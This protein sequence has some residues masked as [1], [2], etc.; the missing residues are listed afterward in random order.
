MQSWFARALCASALCAAPC[1]S[2][3]GAGDPPVRRAL[4]VGVQ[5]YPKAAGWPVLQ[6]PRDDVAAIARVLVERGGFASADVRTLLDAQATHAAIR[7]A[8]RSLAAQSAKGDLLLFY[9]AGHGSR[10]P[11]EEGGDELDGWDETLIP[12]DALDD[13]G[14][15]ND[16]RDDQL[17][18]WVREANARVEDV[19]LVF[20]CCSSGTNSRGGTGDAVRFV[21]PLARGIAGRRG[22]RLVRE[23]GSGWLAPSLS[24]VSLGACRADESAFE[25]V[26]PPDEAGRPPLVR[27]LF[28]WC[29][30]QELACA[31]PQT[32]YAELGERVRDAV[33]RVHPE[34]SPVV[35]GPL[36][37]SRVLGGRLGAA[38]P[39]FALARRGADWELEAGRLQ[40][41]CEGALLDVRAGDGAVLGRVRVDRPGT[42]RSSAVWCVAPPPDAGE[43]LRAQLV[44]RGRGLAPVPVVLDAELLALDAA[45]VLRERIGASTSLAIAPAS[46]LGLVLRGTGEAAVVLAGDGAEVGLSARLDRPDEVRALVQ[47][48]ERW[49]LA[50][51]LYASLSR[52]RAVGPA[53]EVELRRADA[54]GRALDRLPLDAD[55][56]RAVRDGDTIVL[57]LAC[58]TQVHATLLSFAPDGAI[59]V[60]WSSLDEG[61]AVP[62]AK[63]LDLAFRMEIDAG[64]E[65]FYRSAPLRFLWIVSAQ[66]HGRLTALAQPAA[67]AAARGGAAE[68]RAEDGLGAPDGWS[69]GG[70]EL[71]VRRREP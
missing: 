37:E 11:D 17:R 25:H 68:A 41:L 58:P 46:E 9:F 56:A 22:G 63:Q 57:R 70:V 27:G 66:P 52:A 6:G 2:A 4:L 19:V 3:F 26:L 48:L 50:R 53:L 12:V 54:E 8:F 42:S 59:T 1:A 15:P 38:P 14:K 55:G 60:L 39:S 13:S 32:S 21:D 47:G 71:C 64:S 43:R 33:A 5:D 30:E 10:L 35:E 45:R 18:E 44:D 7:D 23:S 24:Y 65:A 69:A 36:A 49:A 28:S 16:V 31:G 20:D 34:Q 61:S 51:A 67:Q 29:L 40:G 62:A